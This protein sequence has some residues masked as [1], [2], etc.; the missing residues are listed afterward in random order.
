VGIGDRAGGEETGTVA[1]IQAVSAMSAE[2]KTREQLDQL[3]IEGGMK[4]WNNRVR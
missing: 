3:V 4:Y 2:C 1:F